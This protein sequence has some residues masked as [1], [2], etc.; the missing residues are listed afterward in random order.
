MIRCYLEPTPGGFRDQA[1]KELKAVGL[2]KTGYELEF[3]HALCNRRRG[4]R[5]RRSRCAG[6][7]EK[8][9]AFHTGF[10]YGLGPNRAYRH[11]FD[12]ATYGRHGM[13]RTAGDAH[14][15]LQR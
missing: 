11:S 15:E 2:R 10:S 3:A 4:Q 13:F 7:A 14:G 6:D 9:S 8:R 12:Y 5:W 1:P